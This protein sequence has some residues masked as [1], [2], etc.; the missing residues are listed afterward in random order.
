MTNEKQKVLKS[1]LD[2]IKDYMFSDPEF[3][4]VINQIKS[5]NEQKKE[6]I[7]VNK[8]LHN[9]KNTLKTQVEEMTNQIKF[10]NSKF[11]KEKTWKKEKLLILYK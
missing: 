1:T 8:D 4:A 9:K 3:Q 5:N 7:T 10:I 2:Q 11:Y 6:L